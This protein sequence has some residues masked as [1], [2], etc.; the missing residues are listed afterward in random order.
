MADSPFLPRHI[1]LLT[2]AAGYLDGSIH[3]FGSM[4][5]EAIAKD[6]RKLADLVAQEVAKRPKE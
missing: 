1:E 2:E 6:L 5:R 4:R 3:H